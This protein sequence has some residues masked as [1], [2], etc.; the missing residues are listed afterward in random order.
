[1]DYDGVG[2]FRKHPQFHAIMETMNKL[3]MARLDSIILDTSRI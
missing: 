1:M 3:N 2:F